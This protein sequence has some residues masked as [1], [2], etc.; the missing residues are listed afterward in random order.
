LVGLA[1]TKVYSGMGAGVVMESI[2]LI[3]NWMPRKP[4]IGSG[5]EVFEEA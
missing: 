3:E 4:E 1:S 2:T 5:P